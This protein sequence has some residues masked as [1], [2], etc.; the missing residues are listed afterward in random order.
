LL[1]PTTTYA[2]SSGN[3]VKEIA[4][5]IPKYDQKILILQQQMNNLIQQRGNI[6][7]YPLVLI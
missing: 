6:N 5:I 7:A 3:D 2:F 1:K 4:E